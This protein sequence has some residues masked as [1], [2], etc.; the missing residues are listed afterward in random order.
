MRCTKKVVAVVAAG[1]LPVILVSLALVLVLLVFAP[2][3][4]SAAQS[5][6][7]SSGT[8]RGRTVLLKD[9]V[10]EI[11]EFHNVRYAEAPVRELR[12]RPPVRY[13]VDNEEDEVDV[14]SPTPAISCIQADTG[15]GL[16]D[17]LFLTV[18]TPAAL[19]NG[20]TGDL[21]PVLMWLHGGGLA[22]GVGTAMGYSF[23]EEST[24]KLGAVTVN[25]NFRLGFLGFSSVE[26]FWD[27]EDGVYANN[28]IRDMIAALDWIQD[29][30]SGFGGDPNLVTVIGESGG[31]TAVLALTCSPL[32]NNKFH[33]GIA[34]SP[35]PEM[36]F[37]HI[38]G[39]E[40]QRTIVEQVGCIQEDIAE[41]GKCLR[42]ITP[43]RFSRKYVDMDSGDGY[44]DFPKKYTE[45]AEV[46]GF[47]V[48]DPIVVTV[49]PR[50]LKLAP[51]TPTAPLS[52][53]VSNMEQENYKQE[54]MFRG[55]FNSDKEMNET[56]SSLFENLTDDDG[57]VDMTWSLY[58]G[59]STT[60]I[61]SLLTCDM[62]STC[63]SNDV[64]AAMAEAPSR[65]IYRLYVTYAF[66]ALPIPAIHAADSIVLFGYNVGDYFTPSTRDFGFSDHYVSMVQKFAK[67]GKFD[68]G[69]KTFP[70]NSMVYDSSGDFQNIIS[71]KPQQTVCE[72]LEEFDLV[73]YG[74]QNR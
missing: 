61:W 24:F 44:F 3:K 13:F 25:I 30:I 38:D 43:E 56:L 64:A 18:R 41:R 67:D 69:W 7:T 54:W 47:M 2:D 66:E 46:V 53:I 1:V 32:A 12:F 15:E 68:E 27:E 70:E 28:G 22:N 4:N 9:G 20:T 40:Y 58:P 10:N 72:K 39:N 35:A 26:E 5:V 29:N 11:H 45:Q 60:D 52:I 51:F 19:G 33:R 65:D 17:C 6:S 8:L 36:R 48:I 73:K 31:A 63:P 23:D 57:M 21:L 71:E 74:W 55:P 37:S 62:R 14:S 42:Q 34:Q 59:R 16:E 49:P 50:E